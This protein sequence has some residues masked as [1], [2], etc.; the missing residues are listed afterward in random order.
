MTPH[1]HPRAR[2]TLTLAA[3]AAVLTGFA[4][5]SAANEREHQDA[6]LRA[7]L[8]TFDVTAPVAP[9]AQDPAWVALGEQLF[10]D[11]ILSGNKD[12]SCATCHH[13]DLATGDGRVLGIG[14]GGVGIGPD[15]DNVAR[16]D[17]TPRNT[18]ALFNVGLPEWNALMWDGRVQRAVPAGA[19]GS[20]QAGRFQTPARASLPTGLNSLLAAQSMFPVFSRDEM[21]GHVGDVDVYGK[22]N[23]VAN[24]HEDAF[25]DAWDRLF[26]EVWAVDAYRTALRRLNPN[27]PDEAFDYTHVANALAAFQTETFTFLE[28]PFDRYLAG[29]SGA[30]SPE[31]KQGA[32]L[33]F[34]EA[35]CA[36]CHRGSLLSDQ[37]FHNLAVPQ[38][39]PG[40]GVL[41][42]L[43]AGRANLTGAPEEAFA[44]RTAPL[45]NVE[46]TGP[47]L[48][49]GAYDTLADVI[50][51]K[52]QPSVAFET[53]DPQRLP[54][55]L[56]ST[57]WPADRI[58]PRLLPS[59]APE[60]SG[61]PALNDDEIEQ[62]VAFLKA[63]TDPAAKAM[64]LELPSVAT[65]GLETHLQAGAGMP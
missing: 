21:R 13:P 37:A 23:A 64:D 26:R 53:F 20:G 63:L 52:T 30:L 29:E 3:A 57:F 65:S 22:T 6:E 11:P 54:A 50:R 4:L 60:L 8:A 33:F 12:T 25:T 47:Y 45:R 41:A 14:T 5:V 48:H 27:T 46:L 36:A 7:R 18:Q 42:P 15:R 43:D 28:S 32:L 16:N 17:P 44:F 49:N 58:G 1:G 59:V 35:G 61:V 2:F 24:L 51:H 31:Q 39:G 40:K 38:F 62:L 34:G 19:P 9:A 55:E 56:Q 10:F